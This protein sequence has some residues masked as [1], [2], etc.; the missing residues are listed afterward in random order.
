MRGQAVVD[1][2]DS[3][4]LTDPVQHQLDLRIGQQCVGVVRC[5]GRKRPDFDDPFT[6]DRQRHPAGHDERQVRTGTEQLGSERGNAVDDDLAA[7]ENEDDPAERC[8]V[9]GERGTGVVRSDRDSDFE[10]DGRCD[11][12][13]L[14]HR[15]E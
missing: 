8:E 13:V 7:V 2:Q 11:Q 3:A 12:S 14:R 15:G 9:L 6:I 1:A 5:R 4:S 10:C